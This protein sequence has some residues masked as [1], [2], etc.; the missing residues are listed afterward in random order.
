MT[1][2]PGPPNNTAVKCITL[3]MMSV[4]PV[5][6]TTQIVITKG[7]VR[8]PLPLIVARDNQNGEHDSMDQ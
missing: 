5:I 3:A 8:V 4:L 7:F 6:T 1:W 2:L